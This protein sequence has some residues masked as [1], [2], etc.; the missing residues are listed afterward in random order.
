MHF[1]A[2]SRDP[3]PIDGAGLAA[4]I[5]ATDRQTTSSRRSHA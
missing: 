5:P 1:T 2:V 3:T 4:R